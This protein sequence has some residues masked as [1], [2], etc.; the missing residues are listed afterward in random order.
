MDSFFGIGIPELILILLIAGIVMGPERIGHTA[1][2][3]GRVTA[4]LQAISQSFMRQINAELDAADEGGALK[5]TWQEVQDLRQQL[6]ELRGEITSVAKG[7]VSDSQKLL[8]ETKGDFKRTIAP[9][10]FNNNS[11]NKTLQKTSETSPE[12]QPWQLP[13]RINVEDDPE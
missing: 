3:L 12:A 6:I 1:R 4:Q 9:P 13:K 8:E 11:N 7:T 10:N 2:W 5:D